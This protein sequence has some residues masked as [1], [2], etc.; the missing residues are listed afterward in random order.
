MR[1]WGGGGGYVV[2]E[3]VVFGKV[4]FISEAAAEA[5]AGDFLGEGT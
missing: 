4:G 2:L 5:P 1:V 3:V